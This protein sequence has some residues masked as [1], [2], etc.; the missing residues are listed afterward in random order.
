MLHKIH[1]G[2][3]LT[4]KDE[5]KVIGY[6]NSDNEYAYSVFPAMPGDARHCEKCHGTGSSAWKMPAVRKH[7]TAQGSPV[8][9]WKIVCG[10]CHDSDDA[11]AHFSLMT[12]TSGQESCGACHGTGN[13]QAVDLKHKSR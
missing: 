13:V 3:Q 5:Y 4:K 9:R 2:S 1:M 10:S 7:P 6:N 12:T 11:S 8:L